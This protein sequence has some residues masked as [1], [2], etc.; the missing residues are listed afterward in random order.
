MY[1]L[2]CRR[3]LGL[4]SIVIMSYFLPR[5]AEGGR[6]A[7]PLEHVDPDVAAAVLAAIRAG[8]RE[9][10]VLQEMPDG[11]EEMGPE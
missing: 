11:W 6:I 9:A 5:S 10:E 4:S 3:R 8:R 2:Y 7:V 1:C